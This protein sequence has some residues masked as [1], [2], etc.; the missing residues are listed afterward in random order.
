MADVNKATEKVIY[1]IKKLDPNLK[2]PV[3][4]EKYSKLNLET[5]LN[6]LQQ[7]HAFLKKELARGG[8]EVNF[9]QY[10]KNSVL[11][12]AEKE[13]K[14]ILK[15]KFNKKVEFVE[16]IQKVSRPETMNKSRYNSMVAGKF[17]VTIY[18]NENYEKNMAAYLSGSGIRP[19]VIIIANQVPSKV[20]F[21]LYNNITI[22][23]SVNS[24]SSSSSGIRTYRSGSKTDVQTVINNL[25]GTELPTPGDNRVKQNNVF[26]TGPSGSGKTTFVDTY[27][28]KL[29]PYSLTC[30]APQIKFH[31]GELVKNNG[32]GF[33]KKTK[34]V[35]ERVIFGKE[36]LVDLQNVSEFK[37]KFVRPTPYN[38]ESSRTHLIYNANG[39]YVY[40][41]A[42]KEN[43]ID[44]SVR[45]LGFNIFDK[46]LQ[47]D[48]M[49]GHDD[50]KADVNYRPFVTHLNATTDFDRFICS[51]LWNIFTRYT[52]RSGVP[53][54]EKIVGYFKDD[55]LYKDV[56]NQT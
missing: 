48:T 46:K 39:I 38:K 17:N 33:I 10:A 42:G 45:A 28:E 21:K 36:R 15:N 31:G 41:L 12:N 19:K 52:F 50:L 4:P 23:G 32:S 53:N 1:D 43:P 7:Y 26:F 2:I 49:R 51:F 54:H 11:K 14:K 25:A 30:F 16:T 22:P 9:S 27:V 47:P 3:P 29:G 35:E 13:F 6:V 5:W 24:V 56:P 40:D 18:R 37:A 55:T 20:G 8:S 44:M 34:R